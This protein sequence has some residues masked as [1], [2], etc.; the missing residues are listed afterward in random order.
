MEVKD[1]EEIFKLI[2]LKSFGDKTVR[3]F[4]INKN[5]VGLSYLNH[6]FIEIFDLKWN[7]VGSV[8]DEGWFQFIHYV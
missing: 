1:D 6:D 2:K 7:L 3:N 8:K 5:L 4:G